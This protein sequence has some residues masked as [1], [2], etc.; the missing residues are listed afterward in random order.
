MDNATYIAHTLIHNIF[1]KDHKGPP[2]L[3]EAKV[4]DGHGHLEDR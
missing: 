2:V 1:Q 3:V 4:L